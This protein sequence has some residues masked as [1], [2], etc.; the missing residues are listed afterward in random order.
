MKHRTLLQLTASAASLSAPRRAVLRAGLALGTMATVL[1]QPRA[2]ADEA[3]VRGGQLIV[4]QFPEPAVLTSGI[5]T[6]GP[7][8]NISGK[9]FDGLLTYDFD[10]RPKP[11]LATAWEVSPDGRTIRFTL[12]PGVTWHDGH[13]FTSADVAFS[14][15]EIWRK[16]HARGRSTFANVTSVETPDPLQVVLDL[17]QPAPFILNA[18]VATESQVLPR[19]LYEGTDILANPH[20]IAPIGTGPFRFASC[21]GTAAAT[22]C[23]NAILGTGT[24]RSPIWTR[25]STVL[26]R[27]PAHG[28]RHWRLAMSTWLV[29]ATSP[30]QTWFG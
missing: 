18:L 14:V 22:S 28:P 8:A 12:R 2:W 29:R 1:D 30:V 17:S 20:N 23:C 6:A 27:M 19:H 13:P 9:I 16:Y 7:T 25:S 21:G 26:F 5:N 4:G 24:S 10:F 11:Q 3:P 15:T